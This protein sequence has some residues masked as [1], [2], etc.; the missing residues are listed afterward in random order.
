MT[1]KWR[2]ILKVSGLALLVTGIFI[3]LPSPWPIVI[4]FLGL[5][6]FLAAGGSG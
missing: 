4:G 1:N 2:T 5:G 6:M 3:K